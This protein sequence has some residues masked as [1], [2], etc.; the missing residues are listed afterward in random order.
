METYHLSLVIA[1]KIEQRS[2]LAEENS[3]SNLITASQA[4]YDLV[5]TKLKAVDTLLEAYERPIRLDLSN[6]S[7]LDKQRYLELAKEVQ[8]RPGILK[9]DS[10]ANDQF[11]EI[12]Q[13]TEEVAEVLNLKGAVRGGDIRTPSESLQ[14]E[15]RKVSTSSRK[16]VRLTDYQLQLVSRSIIQCLEDGSELQLKQIV[17][18][19]KD[20]LSL[21]VPEVTRDMIRLRLYAL[22]NS[23]HLI[24]TKITAT[25]FSF[26]LNQE[27]KDNPFPEREIPGRKSKVTFDGV[28]FRVIANDPQRR[29]LVFVE[30]RESL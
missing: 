25:K 2:L 26:K 20:A 22:I 17:V 12:L 18:K 13:K 19:V 29:K 30:S 8:N 14:I 1:L 27:N 10:P 24:G 15:Q 3:L 7:E 11:K 6:A 16:Q 23:K 9:I 21:R 28:E 5:Q 4:R